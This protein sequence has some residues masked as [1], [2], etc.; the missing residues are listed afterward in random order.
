MAVLRAGPQSPLVNLGLTG[1]Q[2]AL[3]SHDGLLQGPQGVVNLADYKFT[4]YSYGKYGQQT[5][6]Q[7]FSFIKE[8][9]I[10]IQNIESL[11][12]LSRQVENDD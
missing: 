11:R 7:S 6:S 10:T 9:D 4:K 8:E 2:G 3:L 12:N 5:E 1:S